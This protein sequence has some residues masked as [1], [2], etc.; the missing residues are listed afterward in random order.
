MDSLL[1]KDVDFAGDFAM[2][3]GTNGKEGLYGIV[4]KCGYSRVETVFYDL[5]SR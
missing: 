5:I 4:G 1:A 3:V 2:F